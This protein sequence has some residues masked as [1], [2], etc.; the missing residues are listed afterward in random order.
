MKRIVL[1]FIFL[2]VGFTGGYAFS[3]RSRSMEDR[4]HLESSMHFHSESSVAFALM[5][6]RDAQN[7]NDRDIIRRN[8]AIAK[9]SVGLVDPTFYEDPEKQKEISNLASRAKGV[10]SALESSGMCLGSR[11]EG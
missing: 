1:A 9:V 7:R 3:E 5:N 6:I 4:H 11:Q 2:I 10:I 8:C